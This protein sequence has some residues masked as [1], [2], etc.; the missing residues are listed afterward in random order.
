M[1]IQLTVL[2]KVVERVLAPKPKYPA[3]TETGSS[4]PGM[5]WSFA[6]G[7]NLPSGNSFKIERETRQKLNEFAKELRSFRSVD[8]SGELPRFLLL[9]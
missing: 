2:W 9:I 8:L 7:T 5:K 1:L 4:L 6:P 3:S